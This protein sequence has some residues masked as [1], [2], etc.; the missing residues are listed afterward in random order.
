MVDLFI[1]FFTRLRS[2]Q[3]LR[4]RMIKV[5]DGLAV[6][7]YCSS[8]SKDW[9]WDLIQQCFLPFY[10]FNLKLR[11]FVLVFP[12]LSSSSPTPLR[13]SLKP[14]PPRIREECAEGFRWADL[15]RCKCM[16][17]EK[18]MSMQILSRGGERWWYWW[19]LSPQAN[20]IKMHFSPF[21]RWG[22][23]GKMN[24]HFQEFPFIKSS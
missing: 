7:I 8:I 21:L 4:W 10:T 12:S 19:N 20:G 13:H 1:F 24:F 22:E 5:V 9:N 6:T 18:S 2:V 23:M 11:V 14:A 16:K 15:S 3:I 17:R